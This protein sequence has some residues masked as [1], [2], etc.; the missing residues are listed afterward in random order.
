V[1]DE[2]EKEAKTVAEAAKIG[3]EPKTP[4]TPGGTK[5]KKKGKK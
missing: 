2:K 3:D 5:K 4:V 1:T